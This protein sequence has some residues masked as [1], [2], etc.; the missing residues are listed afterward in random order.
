MAVAVMVAQSGAGR[1]R[2]EI[3]LRAVSA[4]ALGLPAA[5]AVILGPPWLPM[6]VGAIAAVM[7]WEWSRVTR[8]AGFGPAGAALALLLVAAI[9]AAAWGRFAWAFA[10]VAAAVP[11]VYGL[12][13]LDE[14]KGA[15]ALA[16]GALYIGVPALALLWLY[17]RP[18]IGRSLAI[19]LICVVIAADI[20]AY[21]VGRSLRGPKLA[22]RISPGKTWSGAAGGL[23]GALI[24]GLALGLALEL[25]QPLI[26]AA[27]A[28]AFAIISQIGDL[29]ES[30][31]K[32]TYRVKDTSGILPGH[33]GMMDRVDGIVAVL[34]AAALAIWIAGGDVRPWL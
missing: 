17:A 14:R 21:F 4:I 28:I 5:A 1:S 7:A 19:W 11:A 31:L 26:L 25:A 8:T 12:A 29:L 3:A 2:S 10:I 23:A 6:F 15:A 27:A 33:G 16:A 18:E 32:R 20:A 34:A 13:R 30:G 24:V 9:A 22:P